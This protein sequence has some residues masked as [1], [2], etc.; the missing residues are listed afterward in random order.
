[1]VDVSGSMS[2]FVSALSALRPRELKN[3]A[4]W[5]HEGSRASLEVPRTIRGRGGDSVDVPRTTS[6]RTLRAFTRSASLLS[7][8]YSPT[9]SCQKNQGVHCEH[10]GACRE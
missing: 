1:M 7:T 10:R 9:T 8:G 4:G 5:P 3:V 2:S 6:G